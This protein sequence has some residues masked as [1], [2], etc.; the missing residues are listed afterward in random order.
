M[1]INALDLET[2]DTKKVKK[3]QNKAIHENATDEKANEDKTIHENK[4]DE[5]AIE[6][7]TIHENKN[8]EKANQELVRLKLWWYNVCNN[9]TCTTTNPCAP[10]IGCSNCKDWGLA[11]EQE[12]S[13]EEAY[14]AED[15]IRDR[16][17]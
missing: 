11:V 2:Y 14:A 15:A 7:D 10:E 6:D 3:L 17:E 12:W 16:V 1:Q 9:N 5:K 4:N 8:D 13:L